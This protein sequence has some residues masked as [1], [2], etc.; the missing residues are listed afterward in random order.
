WRGVGVISHDPRATTTELQK[1]SS[2]TGNR[3][4]SGESQN[5]CGR[6]DNGRTE[7]GKNWTK[8]KGKNSQRKYGKQHRTG[9]GE[10][11]TEIQTIPKRYTSEEK[12][13]EMELT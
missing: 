13:P 3:K 2:K 5:V 10:N 8:G 12:E 4:K 11:I 1:R 7:M 9:N 6:R